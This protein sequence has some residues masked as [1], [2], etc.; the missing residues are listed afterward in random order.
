MEPL[1]LTE[2]KERVAPALKES[3]GVKNVHQI[4]KIE[5]IVINSCVGNEADRKQALE[6]VVAEIMLITG[7]KPVVTKAKKSVSNF[8]LRA[9]DPLG[10]VVTLRGEKMWEFLLRFMR[11]AVPSIRDF[12]GI[13]PKSFDG[14]GN[15]TLGVSDQTI[16]PEVEMDKVK[17]QIGFDITIVTTATTNDA[18]Y[19]LLK[20]TGMPFRKPNVKSSDKEQAA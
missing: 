13:S 19:E 2:Y 4:P 1:L 8:K 5:K 6:D 14:R 17:R 11:V 20:E 7:Q 9:G 10:A 12:R 3:L 16:F 15:Y 18:A